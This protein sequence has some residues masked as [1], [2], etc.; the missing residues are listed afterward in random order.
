MTTSPAT[1]LL[2]KTDTYTVA[3]WRRVL[4]LVWRGQGNPTGIERSSVLFDRWVERLGGQVLSIV[5]LGD[6]FRVAGNGNGKKY[7]LVLA[8]GGR[9]IGL[10]I[11]R[12]MWQQELVIKATQ[13]Q[14]RAYVKPGAA[15][16]SA[17]ALAIRPAARR[18]CSLVPT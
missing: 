4:M 11:D 12:L 9:K 3:A 17:A 13:S 14:S 10:L 8:L 7:V 6:L 2:E 5:S 16:P 1:E 15:P 18:R